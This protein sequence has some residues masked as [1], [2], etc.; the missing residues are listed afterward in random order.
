MWVAR[1]IHYDYDQYF[2][3]NGS[4]ASNTKKVLKRKR[5]ICLDYAYLM[6][7]LC[8]LAGIQNTSIFGYCKDELFD[9]HDSLYA[10][11]HA[12]NA[13]K[14]DGKW[15]LYDVT[16]SSG[17]LKTEFKPFSKY[18]LGQRQKTKPVFRK[19]K[20]KKQKTFILFDECGHEIQPLPIIYKQKLLNRFKIWVLNQFKLKIRIKYDEKVNYDYYLKGPDSYSVTHFPDQPLWSLTSNK[21]RLVFENDSAF[22]HLDPDIE[23]ARGGKPCPDCDAALALDPFNK[24]IKLRQ[25]SYEFNKRNKFI[26]SHC[27]YNLGMIYFK[28]SGEKTDSLAKVSL[29]DSSILYLEHARQSQK[30]AIKFNEAD[31]IL[32]KTK[33]KK[34]QL[35]LLAEN[36]NHLAFIKNHISLANNQS[37][38]L[39]SLKSRTK[40]K[41]K[42]FD[43]AEKKAKE[44]IV[45]PVS[46]QEI[47]KEK[48]EEVKKRA[49]EI[50]S[51]I[52]SLRTLTVRLKACLD[53]FLFILPIHIWKKVMN[54]DSLILP[55]RKSTELRYLLSDNYKKNIVE[56]RENISVYENNY[57]KEVL[58]SIHKASAALTEKVSEF[59]NLNQEKIL[60]QFELLSLQS[61]LV[62]AAEMNPEL[63]LQ[64]KKNLAGEIKMDYCWLKGKTPDFKAAI[65]GMAALRGKQKEAMRAVIL[66]NTVERQRT[67]YASEE[68]LRRKKKLKRIAVHN[69]RIS[70]AKLNLVKKAK[71][72]FLNELKRQRIKTAKENKKTK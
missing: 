11:N 62:K 51:K 60:F 28:N 44:Q 13:V 45:P 43:R 30:L 34:K 23:T 16:F 57:S 63:M 46:R 6:D 7:T 36:Q 72:E 65:S 56:T 68:L 59:V 8:E 66:E 50:E 3:S 53:S 15:Y 54:H 1:N 42:K 41:L 71:R 29:L 4:S 22:Y 17:N 67:H 33:N 38:E 48:I 2:S 69:Y 52:D 35:A 19:K 61:F 32:Q 14:L 26:S 39:K 55:I 5:G 49:G 31:Y 25:E 64:H 20:I 27:E 10:D 40:V 9:V 47:K 18:I 58:E 12:W 70:N 21:Q 37:R 24:Y